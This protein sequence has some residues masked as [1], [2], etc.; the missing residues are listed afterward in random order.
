MS[1]FLSETEV[2]CVSDA[3]HDT[4]NFSVNEIK[5]PSCYPKMLVLKSQ[6]RW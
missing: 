4:D 5:N 3:W 2:L 1:G 6:H